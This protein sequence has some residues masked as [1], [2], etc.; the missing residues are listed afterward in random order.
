MKKISIGLIIVL[1]IAGGVYLFLNKPEQ[2]TETNTNA[3]QNEDENKNEN[4]GE[5][6][7][8]DKFKPDQKLPDGGEMSFILKNTDNNTMKYT[9]KN[10]EDHEIALEFGSS[11]TYDFYIT[12]ENGQEVYR[13]SDGKS[14]MQV[15]TEITLAQGEEKT[16]DLKIPDLGPGDYTLTVFL[17]AQGYNQHETS[18][19][20]RVE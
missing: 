18:I 17:A 8:V 15:I 7:V 20:F 4:E 13:D 1:L 2:A 19:E 16:F 11:M 14:Y 10:E 3:D 12:D 6:K 9:I 5:N